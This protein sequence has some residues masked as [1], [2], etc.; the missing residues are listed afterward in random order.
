MID[1]LTVLSHEERSIGAT[2]HLVDPE[3]VTAKEVMEIL[4]QAYAGRPTSYRASAR[5]TQESLRY[6]AVRKLFGGTPRESI[7]YLNHPVRFDTRQATDL[8]A[9]Q[10]VRC[11]HFADYAEAMVRFYRAHEHD[12]AYAPAH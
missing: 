7:R 11:P 9:R 4:A 5:I 2:L 1:A 12:P 10:G 8:L 3:P 6:A